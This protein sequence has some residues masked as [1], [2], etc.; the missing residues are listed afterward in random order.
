M[1]EIL[2]MSSFFPFQ[3]IS[4]AHF[5]T[6]KYV[7]YLC[8]GTAA[9]KRSV[10]RNSAGIIFFCKWGMSWT[11][12]VVIAVNQRNLTNLKLSKVVC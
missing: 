3:D 4:A 10:K 6:G 5:G 12:V 11:T 9:K 2:I 7:R 1:A 8:N